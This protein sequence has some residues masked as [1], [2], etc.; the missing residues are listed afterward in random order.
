MV[1]YD[2]RK[3]RLS[4]QYTLVKN[5][6]GS[7]TSHTHAGPL[8]GKKVV[9]S[10]DAAAADTGR[11]DV[12]GM[13]NRLRK[14]TLRAAQRPGVD[15]EALFN[16]YDKDGSGKIEEEE[17]FQVLVRWG[18]DHGCVVYRSIVTKLMME[19]DTS[20]DG[21]ISFAEFMGYIVRETIIDQIKEG[22]SIEEIFTKFDYDLSG[23]IDRAEFT[24]VVNNFV[25]GSFRQEGIDTLFDLIDKDHNGG[26]DLQ[27]LNRFLLT[28]E[29]SKKQL[30]GG[31]H[32]QEDGPTGRHVRYPVGAVI[33]MKDILKVNVTDLVPWNRG[34][35]RSANLNQ[36]Y[37]VTIFDEIGFVT[38]FDS[39]PKRLLRPLE[40][41]ERKGRGGRKL[42][43]PSNRRGDP[44][45]AAA[46]GST[47]STA[48]SAAA[49]GNAAPV[50]RGTAGGGRPEG[51]P[52]GAVSFAP[53]LKSAAQNPPARQQ[54]QQPG[55]GSSEDDPA[56][57]LVNHRHKHAHGLTAHHSSHSP[58]SREGAFANG[59]GSGNGQGAG[60]QGGGR[61]ALGR[62][63]QSLMKGAT[64]TGAT[65]TG[66][67]STSRPVLQPGAGA[68]A[69]G[70]RHPSGSQ[71]AREPA[72][73][74]A[75][76]SP[77]RIAER[78]PE[79]AT[80]KRDKRRPPAQAST[81]SA[82]ADP[83]SFVPLTP[84]K[85]SPSSLAFGQNR[86]L[87]YERRY[88]S[89][90]WQPEVKL[91][92]HFHSSQPVEEGCCAFM[93]GADAKATALA[94]KQASPP[95]G[96]PVRPARQRRPSWVHT[97]RLYFATDAPGMLYGT[98][99]GGAGTGL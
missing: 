67:T 27:E 62:G 74:S 94:H 47:A 16:E 29:Q 2:H 39:V 68:G 25:P 46:P 44:R 92:S 32:D 85:A 81:A 96:S 58:A 86:L 18:E 6:D 71:S 55:R 7:I 21:A 31:F 3:Q 93:T 61:G 57:L 99:V 38:R 37:D 17:L 14:E 98:R 64:A 19:M 60:A 22:A 10:S 79:R 65:A 84:L 45:V 56:R 83:L 28:K 95:G 36:T 66:G 20:S 33:E 26:I 70:S 53:L 42:G 78:V 13:A 34:F 23:K 48:Q 59:N 12:V 40:R 69:H 82:G 80:D 75:S 15:V 91:K 76:S 30:R 50:E 9:S 4:V 24:D 43:G 52:P 1:Q 89:Q 73:A 5:A 63:G 54:Q 11:G 88:V 49:M 51:L 41:E 77:I 87:P 8:S 90:Y 35:I 72:P 97:R